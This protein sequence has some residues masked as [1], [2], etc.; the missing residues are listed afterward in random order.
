MKMFRTGFILFF[1]FAACGALF[2]SGSKE[3]SMESK[4]VSFS[5]WVPM[6]ATE[7]SVI[8]GYHEND[9][10]IE[11]EKRTGVHIDFIHPAVGQEVEAYNL[12]IASG[13]LPDMIEH[14]EA[15][16]IYPGGWD[17]AMDVGDFLPLNDLIKKFA[18]NYQ[19]MIDSD[20]MILKMNKTDTG[21]IFG[22]HMLETD[23]QPSYFG[24]VVRKDW[25][26]DLGMSIPVTIDNWHDMLVAFKNK[27]NAKYPF[28]MERR[29]RFGNGEFSGA[30]GVY[31]DLFIDNGTVKYGPIL[32]GWKEY[33]T[34]MRSWLSEGLIDP[35]FISWNDKKNNYLKDGWTGAWAEGFWMFTTLESRLGDPKL[36]I[37]PT[38]YPVLKVGDQVHV[39][40]TNYKVRGFHTSITSACK[41][42]EK[43]VKWLDYRYSEKGYMLFNYGIEGKTYNLKDGKV[44][45]TDLIMKN[46][47][48]L[49]QEEAR[50]KYQQHHGPYVR[51]WRA[52]VS[53]FTPREI[54]AHDVWGNGP[55][56][57]MIPRLTLTPQEATERASIMNDVTTYTEQMTIKFIRGDEPLSNFDKYVSVIKG[58]NIDQAIKITNKAYERFMSR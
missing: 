46:P 24:P 52:I 2:A 7:A 14:L 58:M 34:T 55:N 4:Q 51:D 25:L 12:M 21:R 31:H 17:E 40:Q 10:F 6:Q 39:R 33:L 53:Q 29:G 38:P 36:L 8:K 48:G 11:M 22:F 15:S 44:A 41:M 5:Y 56:D 32:P 30:F 19:R 35:E 9:V 3:E 28:G 26:D 50:R 45:F 47:E 54:G 16:P 42:P 57:G 37:V 43:A 27:K 18:P 23:I 20:P 1:A 13:D 49:N